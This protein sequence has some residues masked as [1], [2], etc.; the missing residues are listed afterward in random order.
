MEGMVANVGFNCQSAPPSCCGENKTL[1]ASRNKTSAVLK[2]PESSHTDGGKE[3]ERVI[4]ST[5]S[6]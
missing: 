1:C 3:T 6:P 4:C 2:A 5:K